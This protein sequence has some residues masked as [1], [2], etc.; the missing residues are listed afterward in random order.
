[1]LS[2]EA[3][4]RQTRAWHHCQRL[5]RDSNFLSAADISRARCNRELLLGRLLVAAPAVATLSPT[6]EAAFRSVPSLFAIPLPQRDVDYLSLSAC[7]RW[8]HAD[9]PFTQQDRNRYKKEK[10]RPI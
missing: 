10:A 1:M 5:T 6:S 7:D 4:D 9:I 8:R 3:R 2:G